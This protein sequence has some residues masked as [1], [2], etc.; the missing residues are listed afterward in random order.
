MSLE[1]HARRELELCG[2]YEEDPA[3]SESIIRAVKEFASYGHSGGSASVAREQLHALL[4]FKTLSLITSDP[5]EWIDQS[6]VSGTPMWQNR[7]DPSYFSTDGGKTWYSLD[8][9]ERTG[10]I[11]GYKIFGDLYD[12]KDVTIIREGE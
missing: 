4:T 5:E 2:Q 1:E 9:P 10:R 3:Y 8:D 6:E 7:R 11:I 12:P